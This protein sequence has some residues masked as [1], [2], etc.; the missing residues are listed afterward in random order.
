MNQY[1][2]THANLKNRKV[3]LKRESNFIS[4][5]KKNLLKIL[6]FLKLI[7]LE[8]HFFLRTQFSLNQALL[9]Q[10]RRVRQ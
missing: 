7:V 6:F 1:F 10:G 2:Y 9:K 3:S 5:D 4:L 8:K